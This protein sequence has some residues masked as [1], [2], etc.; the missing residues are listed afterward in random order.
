MGNYL[1][2]VNVGELNKWILFSIYWNVLDGVEGSYVYCNGKNI[3]NFIVV[4]RIG[5]NYLVFGD[6]NISGVVN[7]DGDIVLFVVYKE[8][9]MIEFDIKLYY[10][11]FCFKWYNIDYY[12]IYY[13]MVLFK[14]CS[15]FI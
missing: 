2:N 9:K 8:F 1:L 6:I 10:Y 3:G 4:N 5:F 11:V 12:I 13:I 15:E 14:W 7:L